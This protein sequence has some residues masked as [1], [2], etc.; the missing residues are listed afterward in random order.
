MKEKREKGENELS[1]KEGTDQKSGEIGGRE[2]YDQSVKE[3]IVIEG[4]E[5]VIVTEVANLI[6]EIVKIEMIRTEIETAIGTGTG[7]G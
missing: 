1:A 7:I 3:K 2:I 4:C 5:E 6:E